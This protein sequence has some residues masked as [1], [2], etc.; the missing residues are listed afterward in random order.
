MCS[1]PIRWTLDKN[2]ELHPNPCICQMV[3]TQ[4]FFRH[5]VIA[6]AGEWT[7][8]RTCAWSGSVISGGT[9]WGM[10]TVMASG[11]TARKCVPQMETTSWRGCVIWA[12]LLPWQK[13]RW[14]PELRA[15]TTGK[16]TNA[17]IVQTDTQIN[18]Y[19][20]TCWEICRFIIWDR[21]LHLTLIGCNVL[22]NLLVLRC[23]HVYYNDIHSD[24]AL[25]I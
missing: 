8:V 22:L 12:S 19:S 20:W 23:Y 13:P 1:E 5:V 16:V 21:T 24:L 9:T 4:F 6:T 7:M 3:V 15:A 14:S 25:V 17:H 2:Q 10:T 11:S 18:E